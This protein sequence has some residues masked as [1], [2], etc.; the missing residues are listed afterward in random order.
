MI[1]NSEL[2]KRYESGKKLPKQLKVRVNAEMK[3]ACKYRECKKPLAFD[4]KDKVFCNF[5]HKQKEA[6]CVRKLNRAKK[7][8]Y[9]KR[10]G[11]KFDKTVRNRK[12]EKLHHTTNGEIYN[13][14][15]LLYENYKE[16]LKAIEKNKGFGYYGTVAMTDDRQYIQCH[17]CGNL[18]GSLGGHLRTHKIT[19]ERYKEM[20]ELS[21]STALVSE[22]VRERMQR[23][24]VK[25]KLPSKGDLPI[26]LQEYN[27]KVQSGQIRHPGTKRK[28]GGL[29]LQKRN[30][31][32]L[33]PEQVLVKIRELADK[34]GHTPSLEEFRDGYNHKY[35]GSITY[36]H[37]SYLNAVKKLGL[38]SAKEVKEHTTEDLLQALRDFKDE[39]GRIP[40]TS[41][42]S[43][44][45]LPARN[46]Y[47]HR[48]GSLNNARVEAGLNAV[49]PLPFGQIVEMTPDQYR[50][51]QEKRNNG[52]EKV[53]GRN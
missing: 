48:F 14:Q 7:N 2:K 30:E 8:A 52:K 1:S 51:Y 34:L 20:Y 17:I 40:M 5:R 22:P 31:L 10:H 3:R 32:G 53:N 16:P 46:T 43:R 19:A 9:Y 37:G 13:G 38:K 23:D 45:L 35:L 28:Q 41:D 25:K 33:C 47:F 50:E 29:S 15:T 27:K 6:T 39:H 49:L 42:F 44:G 4:R 12:I 11:I 26:W 24:A 18:F 36:Q 21:A